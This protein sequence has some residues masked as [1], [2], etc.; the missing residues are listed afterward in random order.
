MFGKKKSNEGE[1]MMKKM[2]YIKSVLALIL[3]LALMLSFSVFSKMNSHD[4]KTYYNRFHGKI[5]S[6]V[7]RQTV[8]LGEES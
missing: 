5:R 2:K 7:F 6:A 8:P 3:T 4:R 1:L